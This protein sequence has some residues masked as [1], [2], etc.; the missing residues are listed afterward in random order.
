[1]FFLRWIWPNAWVVGPLAWI[2]TQRWWTCP[3][4][5]KLWLPRTMLSLASTANCMQ[6]WQKSWKIFPLYR[7]NPC[8]SRMSTAFLPCCGS[9]TRPTAMCSGHWHPRTNPSSSV[10]QA[11]WTGDTTS[12]GLCKSGTS[13]TT[14]TPAELEPFPLLRAPLRQWI[15]ESWHYPCVLVAGSPPSNSCGALPASVQNIAAENASARLG[16]STRRSAALEPQR[17][18][19]SSS[20]VVVL[21]HGHSKNLCHKP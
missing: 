10:P 19:D 13:K 4:F 6:L 8:A 3:D 7:S 2:F 12:R 17:K 11:N 9:S 1:M 20:N 14:T 5:S 16:R 18:N 15:P 21:E